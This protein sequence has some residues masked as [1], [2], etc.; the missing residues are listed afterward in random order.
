MPPAEWSASQGVFQESLAMNSEKRAIRVLIV[1]DMAQVRHDLCT[2]LPLF[3][4]EAGIPIQ[5]VGEAGDGLEAIRQAQAL[6]PD[7]VLMDLAMPLLDGFAAAQA[8]KAENP[9]IRVIALTVHGSQASRA[10]ACLAGMD[11]F[12]EKGDPWGEILQ[13]I[14]F[15]SQ[16]LR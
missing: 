7:A 2:V 8:I 14:I 12:V 9:D 3:G 10:K 4:D 5:V 16:K 11:G 1:D 13:A 6:H 15:C